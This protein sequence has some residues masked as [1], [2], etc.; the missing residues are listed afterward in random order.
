MKHLRFLLTLL[1]AFVATTCATV[2]Q[3]QP[4]QPGHTVNAY[5]GDGYGLSGTLL[6]YN[7]NVRNGQN[8]SQAHVVLQR[9]NFATR[10]VETTGA[11]YPEGGYVVDRTTVNGMP[12]T[13][14]HTVVHQPQQPT[15]IGHLHLSNS[16]TNSGNSRN[17]VVGSSAS[18]TANSTATSRS[19]S[20]SR[21][22]STVVNRNAPAPY[23][24]GYY[25]YRGYR[26]PITRYYYRDGL[27]V[28]Y[29]GPTGV[30]YW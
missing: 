28:G 16:I 21:S 25:W 24:Y 12:L 13:P 1:V 10:Q 4:P 27:R 18:A 20:I 14:G 22:Y 11:W 17:S 5:S 6:Q 30:V 8:P 3:A 26:Y 29:Y 19:T 23:R 2:S 7:P 15:Y 9:Y